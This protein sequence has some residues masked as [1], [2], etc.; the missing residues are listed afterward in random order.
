MSGAN[1]GVFMTTG[2]A[3]RDISCLENAVGYV[4]VLGCSRTMGPNRLSYS[5]NLTGNHLSQIIPPILNK[6][7]NKT[8]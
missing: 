8:L 6:K 2:I 3:E 5:L 1:I 7:S 4:F